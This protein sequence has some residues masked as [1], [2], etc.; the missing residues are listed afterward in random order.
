MPQRRSLLFFS[1]MMRLGLKSLWLHRLRT[2]LTALGIVFGVCSVI[3]MLAI[4][5][6]ASYEAQ[7]QIKSLGSENIIIRS[8][9][10][11]E[12]QKV[13]ESA[14]HSY[15][16]DYGLKDLDVRRIKETVPAVERVV[17]ARIIRDYVWNVSRRIDSEIVGTIPEYEIIRNQWVRAGRFFNDLEYRDKSNVCVIGSSMASRLF[18]LEA[19][20]GKD[21]RVG[22]SYFR[23]I[24]V[25][26]DAAGDS[27][28]SGLT[29]ASGVTGTVHS[30]MYIPLTT[31]RMKYGEV[32]MRRRSGSTE[33]EKVELH[34]L[35]V[36]ARDEAA[37]VAVAGHVSAL[38]EQTHKKRDYTMLVPLELLNRAE[39]TKRIFNVVLGS[40]AAISLLVGGIGIMNIML[41][42]VTERTREIGIRRALGAK[43]SDVIA[44]FLFE[45]VILSGMGGLLG[46]LIGVIIPHAVT[47]FTEMV[48]IVTFWSPVI[49]F[50]ISA[51]VGIV[52][53]IYPAT[54]AAR[55][56]PVE[57][58][59][60]E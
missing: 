20:L 23:V 14:E 6:G 4:G 27:V 1:R 31:A 10:P 51:L 41:A 17:P 29:V 39:K 58:L 30:R 13:T 7:E 50:G 33:S 3:A 38:L 24:G 11:A 34:E 15:T 16:L 54:R 28:T 42:S 2:F 59:R 45:A 18:P 22:G 36:R 21:L 8:V 53:G 49:A 60:H 52:F 43:R 32:L 48:T 26:E 37:V 25:L 55:M 35:T 12:D 57:A 44:Q 56:D 5:E 19:P 47:V 46:V 9:K 40:I